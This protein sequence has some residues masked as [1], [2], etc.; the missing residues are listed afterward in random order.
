[1]MGLFVKDCFVMSSCVNGSLCDWVLLY[2]GCYVMGPFVMGPLVMG[3]YVW[4]QCY[5]MCSVTLTTQSHKF[6]TNAQP[7]HCHNR[8]R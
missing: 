4:F 7:S 8:Y 3:P 6:I 1:M 5:N 2:R